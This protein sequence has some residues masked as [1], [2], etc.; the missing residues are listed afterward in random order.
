MA[1]GFMQEMMGRRVPQFGAVYVGASWGIIE[2]LSF[3]ED[4]YLVSPHWTDLSLLVLALLLPSVVLFIWTHGRPG[5]DEFSRVEKIAIPANVILVAAVGMLLYGGKDLG[6]V[7]TTV[8]VEGEDGE[9]VERVVPKST[10]RKR[11]ALFTFD[12]PGDTAL[13][14][15]GRGLETALAMDLSQDLFV[16]VR[17]TPFYQERL[18]KTGFEDGLEVP[19]SLKREIAREQNRGHIVAGTLDRAGSTWTAAYELFDADRGRRLE[20][21]SFEGDDL[22]ALAD[23]MSIRLRQDLEIPSRHLEET[24]DLPVTEIFTGNAE[25]LR[26]YADAIAAIIARNDF[27]EGATHLAEAVTLD[28]GF[29]IAHMSLYSVSLL[30]NDNQR[31]MTALQAAVDNIYRLPERQ[32]FQ[33]NAEYQLMRQQHERALATFEMK[34]ELFPDDIQ[35]YAGL[36]Q[37]HMLGGRHAEAI[38][39]YERILELDPAQTEYLEAI[40][41]LYQELGDAEQALAAYKRWAQAS[42]EEHAPLASIG[43]LHRS[44][45]EHEQA[46]TSYERALTLEPGDVGLLVGLASVAQATGRFDDA[47]AL[48]DEA[49]SSARIPQ[50]RMMALD[51][52]QSYHS[53]RGQPIR[54]LEYAEQALVEGARFQ[55][56]LQNVMQ[57]FGTLDLMVQAGDTAGALR[58]LEQLSSQLQGPFAGLGN[59]GEMVLYR[60]LEDADRAEEALSGLEEFITSFGFEVLRPIAVQGRAR[61]H[62]LRHDHAAAAEAYQEALAL[63]P[64][65]A[66]LKGRVGYCMLQLGELQRAEDLLLE[67]VAVRPSSPRSNYE[68]ALVYLELGRRDDAVAHLRTAADVLHDANPGHRIAGLVRAKLAELG[69]E[70]QG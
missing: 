37:I 68:L 55:P 9:S 15:A 4:R 22:F 23:S 61:I 58:T 36:G 27:A 48:L 34:A 46:V 39:A 2:F 25:A 69:E 47:V 10:F 32:R 63:A 26:A 11:V 8:M 62:E 54:A 40:G 45:G 14:W 7:T 19:F 44:T 41:D 67:A 38:A 70:I 50:E 64:L 35:A 18:A 28:P 21:R 43:D 3:I 29:A 33:V 65:E 49:L 16:D 57:R 53:L 6:A 24:V 56:G 31:A 51:A 30:N 66:G 20:E 13:A 42:P 1:T 59:I 12:T 60:E 52:F 17:Y 5:T